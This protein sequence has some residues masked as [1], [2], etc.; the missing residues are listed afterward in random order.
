MTSTLLEKY[1][2]ETNEEYN[3]LI[4]QKHTLVSRHFM[5]ECLR[6]IYRA[7]D[8]QYA[9][10]YV[11]DYGKVKVGKYLEAEINVSTYQAEIDLEFS[12]DIAH[13]FEDNGNDNDYD[14][15]LQKVK[16]MI[17]VLLNWEG[18]TFTLKDM[19]HLGD[20]H[21]VV[22][23]LF[24]PTEGETKAIDMVVEAVFEDVGVEL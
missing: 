10:K 15:C 4:K 18:A 19:K 1:I 14:Y 22:R 7:A 16:E 9:L 11:D 12:D 3:K 8:L 5:D 6:E 21:Q 20:F 17:V 2:A 23:Y 24:E 13:E